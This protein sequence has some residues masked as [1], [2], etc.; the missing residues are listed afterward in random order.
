MRRSRAGISGGRDG[1]A[2]GGAAV[3]RLPAA[4]FIIRRLPAPCGR[5]GGDHRAGPAQLSRE[6]KPVQDGKGRQI[7]EQR[8]GHHIVQPGYL[9]GVTYGAGACLR[10]ITVTPGARQQR[11]SQLHLGA[12]A[13]TAARQ[14]DSAHDDALMA[15]DPP[16]EA[17]GLPVRDSF[18]QRSPDLLSAADAA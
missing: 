6:T 14:L 11:I 5:A 1:R 12:I 17:V 7:E 8:K 9:A 10:R 4:G 13:N 18:G 15:E 2:T 16:A 3:Q